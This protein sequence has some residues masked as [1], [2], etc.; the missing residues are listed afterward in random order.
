MITTR[1][2]PASSNRKPRRSKK[3]PVVA[4]GRSVARSAGLRPLRHDRQ[5]SDPRTWRLDDGACRRVVIQDGRT[6]RSVHQAATFFPES[7]KDA[8]LWPGAPTAVAGA[9]Q[10]A[11][12]RRRQC[13][14]RTGSG[15]G[16]GADDAPPSAVPAT[17][18]R[19][20]R[21]ASSVEYGLMIAAICAVLCVGVGVTLQLVFNSTLSCIVAQLRVAGDTSSARRRRRRRRHRRRGHG[22]RRDAPA[23][24]PRPSPSASPSPPSTP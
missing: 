19:G 23:V 18:R 12:R 5:V 20:S 3:P 17:A 2:G 22:R 13:E 7:R 15:G 8:L 4:M 10:W 24:Q 11:E 9:T 6:S 1:S 16:R 14:P 21:G